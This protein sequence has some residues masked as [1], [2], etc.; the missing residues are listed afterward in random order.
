MSSL[1]A[2]RDYLV[3]GL[4]YFGEISNAIK[5]LGTNIINAT[6]TGNKFNQQSD[7]NW[8]YLN[9]GKVAL[10]STNK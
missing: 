10:K 2:S 8:S 4:G 6:H 9:L 3:A 5:I 7:I 1:K